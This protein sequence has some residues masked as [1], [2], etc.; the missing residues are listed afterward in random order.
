MKN[1]NE[2]KDSNQEREYP[3]KKIWVTY[4]RDTDGSLFATYN[5]SLKEKLEER[6]NLGRYCTELKSV[7]SIF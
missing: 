2:I 3:R 4:W 7:C 1:S 5:L 6:N